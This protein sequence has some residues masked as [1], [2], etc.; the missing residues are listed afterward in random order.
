MPRL[1]QNPL[2]EYIR[3]KINEQ[4]LSR[5]DVSVRSGGLIAESYVGA[6]MN[7]TCSNV[8]ID[9]LKALARGLG[10]D[11]L[12]LVRVALGATT[13]VEPEAWGESENHALVLLDLK[14]KAVISSDVAAITH[15]LMELSARE[16]ASVKRFVGKLIRER[17]RQGRPRR[18]RKKSQ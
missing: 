14:N 12:E 4:H 2:S 9:K 1:N 6:I 5:H 16:R 13:P 3:R 15:Q 7:G 8:S 11:E 10:T 17:G 18:T